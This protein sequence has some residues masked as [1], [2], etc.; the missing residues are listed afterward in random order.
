MVAEG[1]SGGVRD[2]FWV[3]VNEMGI[4]VAVG[5]GWLDGEQA[6]I[7]ARSV[8]SNEINFVRTAAL[9]RASLIA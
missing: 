3:G 7:I 9:Q 2:G 1:T 4:C 8:S 6:V 5:R